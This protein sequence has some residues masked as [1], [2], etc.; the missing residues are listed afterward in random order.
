MS[1]PLHVLVVDD[2]PDVCEFVAFGLQSA[3][4]L[5]EVAA[6]GREALACQQRHPADVVITDIFM[7]DMDGLEAIDRIKRLFPH[8][9]IVAMSSRIGPHRPDYLWVAREIGADATLSKPFGTDDLLATVRRL[10]SQ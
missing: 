9:R 3:G 10:A 7:P 8:T 5:V 1:A 4:F 2:Q 6:N